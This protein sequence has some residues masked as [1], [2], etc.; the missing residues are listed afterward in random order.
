ME[1]RFLVKCGRVSNSWK[2]VSMASLTVHVTRI[3]KHISLK[4]SKCVLILNVD[5][6]C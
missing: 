6:E 2:T 5:F 4:R 3:D 1:F